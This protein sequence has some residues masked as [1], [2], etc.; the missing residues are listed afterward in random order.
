MKPLNNHIVCKELKKEQEENE[1]VVKSISR[2]KDLE[3]IVS[4]NDEVKKGDIVKVSVNSGEID[5]DYTIIRYQ[6]IIYVL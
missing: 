2:F 5:E 1:F 3:V 6:D 4:S